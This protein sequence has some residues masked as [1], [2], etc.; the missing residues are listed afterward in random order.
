MTLGEFRRKTK[1][2]PDNID[3]MMDQYTDD[4]RYG[5]VENFEVKPV[6]FGDEGIPKREWA[7]ENCLVLTDQV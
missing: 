4:G 1:H 3:M 7:V 6:T 5:M 2:L